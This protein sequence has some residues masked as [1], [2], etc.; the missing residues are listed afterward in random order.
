MLSFLPGPLVGIISLILYLLNL[1]I[2]PTLVVLFALLRIIT[3]IPFLRQK[4]LVLLHEVL[5]TWWI[6]MSDFIIWLTTKI[7][8]DVQGP[9]EQLSRHNWYFVISNHQ[10]WLDIIILEKIFNRKIPMLKFFMKFELLWSLP[11]AGLACW[12]MGFPFMRRYSKSYLKKHP[13]K[14][15]K[16]VEA[17]RKACEQFKQHPSSVINFLEGTRFTKQKQ[18][19]QASP[20][21][22]LLKPRAGGA[23]FVMSA[24]EDHMHEI[25]DVTIIYPDG[26]INLWSFICGKIHKIII[27]FEVLPI[28][29]EMRGNYYEQQEFRKYFQHW[30]NDR[31]AHKDQLIHTHRK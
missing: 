31:W 30:L 3:P 16:D 29:K 20:Y 23:A 21:R 25:I 6:D 18:L 13:E 11:V 24:L 14:I 2:V 17:T 10:S 27:R 28:T 1:F 15:G 4:L 8:W 9:F 12:L 22:Y 7:E 26:N 19:A 5:P